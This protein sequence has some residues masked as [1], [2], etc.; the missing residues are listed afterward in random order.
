MAAA[1]QQSKQYEQLAAQC[2]VRAELTRLTEEREFYR[3]QATIF[4]KLAKLKERR[5][6]AEH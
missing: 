3:E 1:I 6:A 4:R 5:D 2:D